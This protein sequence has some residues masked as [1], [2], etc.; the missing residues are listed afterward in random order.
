M[1]SENT[2]QKLNS[3]DT[4]VYYYNLDELN[5]TLQT[6]KN[7]SDKYGYHVHYAMKANANP[8]VLK[9]IA[10]YKFGADCVS[11]NEILA[12]LENG[13]TNK[14][15]VYAG[16]GKSDKEIITALEN[17]I[18]C[19]N[20][21]SVQE[22]EVIN[23][24]A[25][26][27]NKK[28]PIAIRLNPNV[29]AKTHKYITTGLEEN[30]FGI[31]PWDFERV[32]EIFRKSKNI[33][34]IGLHFHIGSQITDY[35][36]FKNLCIKVNEFQKWFNNRKIFF[37]HINV[38]G[39]LGIDY[40]NPDDTSNPDFKKFFGIFNEFIDLQDGQQLHFELGRSVIGQ[41]ASLISRVLFVKNGINTDFA[42]ID[43]GMSELLRPALYQAKHMVQ[44]LTS[45]K[46]GKRYDVV[47][48]ICESS[49]LF[50]KSIMLPETQR[51]D[52]MAIRSAGAYG[53]SMASRYNMRDL[54]DAVFSDEL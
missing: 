47:G 23:R 6:V 26:K 50:A 37:E 4:P 20:S 34:L 52:I 54:V 27:L 24:L 19:F 18:F 31:N 2:I 8:R 46:D 1:F 30:K 45:K 21:E 22:I 29:D 9:I 13:F 39:G 42:I 36:V 38:G 7:E 48:P 25:E 44:N 41:C 14:D 12:A 5:N 35:D 28:A 49:D 17:D 33:E 3:L 51:G 40:N 16:V 10:S 53:E 43:A 32:I 15:I 11:G